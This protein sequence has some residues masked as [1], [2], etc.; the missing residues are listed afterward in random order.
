MKNVCLLLLIP[1]ISFRAYSQRNIFRLTDTN[2]TIGSVYTS[3]YMLYDLDGHA[4]IREE[5][6]PCLDSLADFM[7]RHPEMIF[8]IGS[9]TDQRGSDSSNQK[10]SQGRANSVRKYLTDRGVN[11]SALIATGF[12]E[13]FPVVPQSQIDTAKSKMTKERLYQQNRRTEFKIL[14]IYPSSFTLRDSVFTAGSIL[15]INVYFDFNK[16]TIRPESKPL[17]DSIA[18]FLIAHPNLIVEVSNHRDSRGGDVYSTDITKTRARA[19][20]DYFISRGVPASQ[21]MYKGYG[22]S[23]PLILPTYIKSL[24]S[25]EAQESMYQLNRR[26]ELRIIQVN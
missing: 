18:K 14:H 6:W 7:K 12:G 1:L 10:L 25:K 26:T 3:C 5:S 16:A 22:D 20:C 8:E 15:R 2:F 13:Q 23:T 21:V 11:E 4:T 17:L 24:K 9:Y 19:V